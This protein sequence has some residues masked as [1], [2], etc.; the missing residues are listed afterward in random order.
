MESFYLYLDLFFKINNNIVIYQNNIF[1]LPTNDI[2]LFTVH[3]PMGSL[4]LLKLSATT[5][6][7]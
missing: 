4:I 7:W 6:M 1:F 3:A 2:S 5:A